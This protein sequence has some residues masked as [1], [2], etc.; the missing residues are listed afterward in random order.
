MTVNRREF[1]RSTAGAALIVSVPGLLVRTAEA[2]RLLASVSE[3]RRKECWWLVLRDGTPVAGDAGG[4]VLLLP[5]VA[6]GDLRWLADPRGAYGRM[7]ERSK[8]KAASGK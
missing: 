5:I 3:E 8:G 7:A 4:G 6:L 1:V 2:A